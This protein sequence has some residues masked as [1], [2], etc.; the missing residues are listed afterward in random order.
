MDLSQILD[1]VARLW[2]PCLLVAVLYHL[3]AIYFKQL[4]TKRFGFKFT[5]NRFGILDFGELRA[6]YDTMELIRAKKMILKLIASKKLS[7]IFVV[8]A[9]LTYVATIVVRRWLL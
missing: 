3:R 5:G 8:I 9:V 6:T 1:M 7:Y 2:M 4:L